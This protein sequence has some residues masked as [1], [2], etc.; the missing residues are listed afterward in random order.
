MTGAQCSLK[1][2]DKALDACTS[3]GAGNLGYAEGQL[4]A[5]IAE[6]DCTPVCRLSPG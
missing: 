2:C 4:H 1:P 5:A 6:I 3:F